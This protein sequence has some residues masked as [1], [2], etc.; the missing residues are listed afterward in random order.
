M[1]DSDN[2]NASFD[3]GDVSSRHVPSLLPDS[4]D[5]SA[6]TIVFSQL[7]MEDR[8]A[9]RK[10]ASRATVLIFGVALFGL[11]WTILTQFATPPPPEE[12]YEPLGDSVFSLIVPQKESRMNDFR[13]ESSLKVTGSETGMS[14]RKERESGEAFVA[15][16][17]PSHRSHLT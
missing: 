5:V 4:D 2:E 11:M 7:W 16:P 9:E 3:D 1:P 8:L 14:K 10:A 17:L 13:V 6:W 15:Q 12:N